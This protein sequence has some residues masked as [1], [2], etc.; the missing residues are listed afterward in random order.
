MMR[1][2]VA[3]ALSAAQMLALVT[4]ATVNTSAPAAAAGPPPCGNPGHDGSPATV[5]S[6]INSYYYPANGQTLSAGATSFTLANYTLDTGS[7]GSSTAIGAGDMLLIMQMQDGTYNSS[8]TSV[9]NAGTQTIT[10]ASY[11]DGASGSG[12]TSL[13]NA[14]YYEYVVVTSVAGGIVTFQGAGTGNGLIKTYKEQTTTSSGQDGRETFQIVRVPQYLTTQLASNFRGAVWNGLTGG[15]VAVDIATTLN[16]GGASIFATADG[17]RGGGYTIAGSNATGSSADFVQSVSTLGLT[18]HTSPNGTKGEGVVGSPAY[19]FQWTTFTGLTAPGTPSGPSVATASGVDGY[20]GGDLARGAPGNAG[21]GGTDADPKANDQNTGGGGGGNGG[22]GGNG[23]Y[24]WTAAEPKWPPYP[25]V[26]S[27]AAPTANYTATAFHDLGGRGGT[28]LGVYASAARVFMGGGGG[29]GANNN[30]SNDSTSSN[31]P[32]NTYSNYGSSGGPGGG[33]ILMRIANTGTGGG[34]TASLYANGVS[35]LA[36]NNDGGGGAGAGGTIVIT[37]PVTTAGA[38]TGLALYADGGKGTT[39][40]SAANTTTLH[41]PGGGGGGGEVITTSAVSSF[42]AL[43]GAA[44]TTGAT[45]TTYGAVAGNNGATSSAATASQVPGVRSGAECYNPSA[46]TYNGPVDSTDAT[47]GGAAETGA[48]D[49]NSGNVSNANDFTARGLVF[50]AG[51]QVLNTSATAGTP[52]GNTITGLS[53]NPT[54]NVDSE[55]YYDASTSNGAHAITL[56]ATPPA[57]PSGWTVRLCADNAG[58]PNCA[59]TGTTTCVNPTNSGWI[60]IGAAAGSTATAQYCAPALTKTKVTYWAVYTA[61]TTGLVAFTRYDAHVVASDDEQTPVS[62]TTHD[63]IYAGFIVLTKPTPVVVSNGCPAGATYA[64]S[65][66]IGGI[67]PGGILQYTIDYRNI[68]VGAGATATWGTEGQNGHAFPLTAAGT[69]VIT[70]DGTTGTNPWGPQSNGI[71]ELLSAG[72]GGGNTSC[73]SVANKCGDSTAGTTFTNASNGTLAVG[74]TGFKAKIGGASF[75]LY[76][77][78]F[79]SQTGQGTITFAIQIK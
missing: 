10:S 33:I 23:G 73:G 63:E 74:A 64:P 5:G 18:G 75:Q 27:T 19:W 44:G 12:L 70:D 15:V 46:A 50:P 76:P 43:G 47:Y 24:P 13:G 29:A 38:L 59:A 40:D 28:G 22:A 49:G 42:E 39:A 11:G 37:S 35:G 58:S 57:A 34:A 2:I 79:P 21:G 1:R 67:C 32:A 17:F 9:F 31:T 77:M 6:V 8:D 72:L 69:F 71:T 61:P 26:G 54:A 45:P 36:P 30:G 78:N 4:I 51:A 66:P 20:Y 3:A 48:Y 56:T 52:V 14:G 62:N 65:L 7:G 53:S 41:G 25:Q 16:L 55:L 68:A 60:T